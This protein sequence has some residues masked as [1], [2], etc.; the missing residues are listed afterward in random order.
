[1]SPEIALT[2]GPMACPVNTCQCDTENINT[3]IF[4][5]HYRWTGPN[6]HKFVYKHTEDIA[7]HPWM[8][9]WAIPY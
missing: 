2:S 9:E 7:K 5:N 4:E 6:Q 8:D 1:M 3:V